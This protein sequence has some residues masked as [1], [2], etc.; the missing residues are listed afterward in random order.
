VEQWLEYLNLKVRINQVDFNTVLGLQNSAP[1]PLMVMGWR[2]D[3]PDPDSFLRV[4]SWK[5]S[6]GW[7]H[8]DYESLVEGARRVTDRR[9]R[10][11]MYRQA[12]R[13]LVEEAPVIPVA[14]ALDHT[15]IKPWLASSPLNFKGYIL[16]DFIMSE[17]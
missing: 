9:Q 3:Y 17:H 16:K 5:I 6:G 4:A 8:P 2:A 11:A 15:L 12:E 10:L 13:I 1:T 7:R 14:Y